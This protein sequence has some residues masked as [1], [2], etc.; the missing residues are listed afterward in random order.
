MQ[1][2]ADVRIP[3]RSRAEVE[4]LALRLEAD[5]HRVRRRLRA[6]V[7]RAETPEEGER[8]ARWLRVEVGRRPDRLVE[9]APPSP[10]AGWA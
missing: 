5:G 9:T 2:K 4:E 10:F 1:R 8:V 6:V 7:V 3:C